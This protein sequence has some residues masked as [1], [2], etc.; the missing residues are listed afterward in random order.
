MKRIVPLLTRNVDVMF[1]IEDGHLFREKCWNMNIAASD[2]WFV[3]RWTS[4]VIMS[5]IE[6]NK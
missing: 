2:S 4:I 6:D 5:K 1:M 3:A